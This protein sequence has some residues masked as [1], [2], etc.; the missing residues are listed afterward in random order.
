MLLLIGG[1]AAAGKSTLARAWCATRYRAVHL[2][3]DTIRAFIIGGAADPQEPGELQTEQYLLSVRAC[4]ALAQVF[5]DAGYDV[6]LDEVFPPSVFEATWK[7]LL[8]GLDWRLVIVLPSLAEVLRRSRGREKR[9][10]EEHSR[11]QYVACQ[12]WPKQLRIDT[13]GLPVEQSLAL[14]DAAIRTRADP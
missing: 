10:R 1:P 14:F 8:T 6:V 13:T 5:L 11:A 9:V 4:A 2:E 3:L 7:P 12:S